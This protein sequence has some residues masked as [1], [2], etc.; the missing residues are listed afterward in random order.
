META[1]A[2]ERVR[3]ALGENFNAGFWVN[4]SVE[5]KNGIGNA[6]LTIPVSGSKASGK[7]IS[8]GDSRGGV[9]T[10]SLLYVIVDGVAA[11]IVVHNP[12]NVAIPNAPSGV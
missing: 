4:G 1:R 9:W 8:E 7:I 10:L 3:E 5:V 11:P 12:N 6:S 2:D